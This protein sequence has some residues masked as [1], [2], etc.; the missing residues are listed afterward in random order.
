MLPM[1]IDDGFA[2]SSTLLVSLPYIT[3]ACLYMEPN[4]RA[5]KQV[6]T[7]FGRMLLFLVNVW[8]AWA[9]M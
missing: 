6:L 2:K 7:P 5:S 8:F 4:G 1:M 9:G 3:A